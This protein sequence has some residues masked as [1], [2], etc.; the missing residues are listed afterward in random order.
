MSSYIQIVDGRYG[1]KRWWDN[2]V[3]ACAIVGDTFEIH[4]WSD[5]GA[6]AMAALRFGHRVRTSWSGG[7]VIQGRI[8][9]DFLAFL[10]EAK[11][12]TDTEIYNKM[13]PF[14]TIMF[15]N[16]FQSAHYGTEVIVPKVVREKQP[17][18]DRVLDQ[19]TDIA[20]VHRNIR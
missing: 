5:E 10:T 11:K 14:F 7:T 3:R 4:C 12:P 16:Q 15:G 18:I 19:L 1:D 20:V 17:V 9:K 8:T 6:E 2:L 13:T